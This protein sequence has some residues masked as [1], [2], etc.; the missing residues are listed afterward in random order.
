MISAFLLLLLL[1]EVRSVWLC[2]SG[3]Y[4]VHWVSCWCFVSSENWIVNYYQTSGMLEEE[5]GKGS[6]FLG[7]SLRSSFKKVLK[8]QKTSSH[9]KSGLDPSPL[10]GLGETFPEENWLKPS[11]TDWLFDLVGEDGVQIWQ[12]TV[13]GRSGDWGE[14]CRTILVRLGWHLATLTG[15][16]LHCGGHQLVVFEELEE[17]DVL[18]GNVLTGHDLLAVMTGSTPASPSLPASLRFRQIALQSQ[19]WPG[20]VWRSGQAR[21]AANP[22]PAQP[23]STN[24]SGQICKVGQLTSGQLL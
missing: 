3:S 21:P 4:W 18:Q 11:L 8:A 13:G 9:F 7:K 5:T 17:D 22:G 12:I 1:L 2:H 24:Q 14:R 19:V 23:A 16:L 15:S 20:P 6:F 10:N